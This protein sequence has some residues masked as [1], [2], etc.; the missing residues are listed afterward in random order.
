MLM[1]VGVVL[2]QHSIVYADTTF[3]I[4]GHFTDRAGNAIANAPLKARSATNPDIDFTTDIKGN[5]S[6]SVTPDRYVI[7][8]SGEFNHSSMNNIY[9]YGPYYGSSDPGQYFIDATNGNVTQ[10]LQLDDVTLN[11]NFVNQ[12]NQPIS[13]AQVI[14][15][16]AYRQGGTAVAVGHSSL[17]YNTSSNFISSTIPTDVNGTT[18]ATILKGLTYNI[19]AVDPVSSVQY[20]VSYTPNQNMNSITISQGPPPSAP[21]NLSAISPTKVPHLTWDAVTNAT[22]YNIYRNNILIGTSATNSYTDNSASSG[23]NAYYVSAV[24]YSS[25]ESG[26]SNTINVSV[27]NTAP[28]VTNVYQVWNVAK[29][30]TEI[31]LTFSESVSGLPQG[32]YG[33]GTSY[34]KAF[35]NTKLATV[36]FID[37][38][39]NTGMTTVTPI[40]AS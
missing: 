25:G 37:M 7:D 32:W 2:S 9:F 30:R 8:S 35:Y 28:V 36:T 38:V 5:Y 22:S 31:T 10:D 20:C 39:G 27:D 3:T 6:I 29:Q 15:T 17:L 33:N 13:G 21:A 26:S 14:V 40:G 24:R 1:L 16:A 12:N 34:T 4:S 11:V 23:N 18:S 19:C